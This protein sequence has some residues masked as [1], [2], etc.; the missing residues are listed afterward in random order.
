MVI[1]I[2]DSRNEVNF[3]SPSR[4]ESRSKHKNANKVMFVNVE[5]GTKH[6]ECIKQ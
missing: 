5:Q 3:T 1:V 6:G 2:F 4:E